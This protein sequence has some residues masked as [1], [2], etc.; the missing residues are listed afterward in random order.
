MSS[1]IDLSRLP[2][3]DA[4]RVMKSLNNKPL[5]KDP[6]SLT[7]DSITNCLCIQPFRTLTSHNYFI[8]KNLIYIPETEEYIYNSGHNII[9]EKIS[10]KSQEIIPLTHRCNVTSLTYVKSPN[11][12]KMVFIG[13]KLFPDEK[14]MIN[15]GIEIIQIEDKNCNKKLSLNMGAYVNYNNYVYDIIAKDASEILVIILKNLNTSINEVKLFF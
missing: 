14:N 13:E 8:K 15:G 3:E 4:A 11:N 6:T 1:E 9:V 10:N 12:K 2:E 5:Y 7:P